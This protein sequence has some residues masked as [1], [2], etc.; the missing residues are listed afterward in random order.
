M[1]SFLNHKAC[2]SVE[3]AKYP[4]PPK[5][6][7]IVKTIEIDDQCVLTLLGWEVKQKM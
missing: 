2:Y 6:S 1:I 3:R 7:S 4:T 5:L